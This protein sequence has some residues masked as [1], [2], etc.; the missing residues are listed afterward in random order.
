VRR[1]AALIVVVAIAGCG[2]DDTSSTERDQAISAAMNAYDQAKA[3][4][5]DLSQGPC[6]AENLPGLADWVAD[7]AHDPR[8]DIDDQPSNQCRRYRDGEASHFVELTPE[9]ALI[10]AE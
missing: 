3:K 4:G 10:R 5:T 6:I 9:G 1:A 2:G 7:I 8:T